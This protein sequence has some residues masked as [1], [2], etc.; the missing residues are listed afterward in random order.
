MEIVLPFIAWFDH[1]NCTA[2]LACKSRVEPE[3]TVVSLPATTLGKGYTSIWVVSLDAHP[4]A[5]TP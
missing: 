4:L 3:Q 5:S 1:W 2:P